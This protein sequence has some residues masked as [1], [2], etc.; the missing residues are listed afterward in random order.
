MFMADLQRLFLSSIVLLIL[1]SGTICADTLR[2]GFGLNRPPY[3]ISDEHRGIE[4]DIVS[5]LLE[6]LGYQVE[7][8]YIS[9]KGLH[10]AVDDHNLDVATSVREQYDFK[11]RYYSAP[12]IRYHNVAIARTRNAFKLNTIADLNGHRVAAWQL[13]KGD[14][15]KEF[16]AVTDRLGGRYFEYQDQIEQNRAFWQGRADIVII[17]HAIFLWNQRQLAEEL[18]TTDLITVYPLFD[19]VTEFTV[20]FKDKSLRDAFNKA[21]RSLRHS[22]EYD[23][24]VKQY[25][26]AESVD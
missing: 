20:S 3:V 4:V 17:D 11:Q 10:L 7:P 25:I 9:N 22:G 19:G 26:S 16:R 18:D 8:V 5:T 24:I 23:R 14:L 2:V 12:Y 1:M 6:S 21:L 13:A 15:G